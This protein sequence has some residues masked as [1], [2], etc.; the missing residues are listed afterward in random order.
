MK[1]FSQSFFTFLHISNF[2]TQAIFFCFHKYKACETIHV[3]GNNKKSLHF[4]NF[5]FFSRSSSLFS[6]F[7]I[8]FVSSVS[9]ART[10]ASTNMNEV[11]SRSH[12]IFNI[13][14]TQSE[15]GTETQSKISL[16]DLAGSERASVSNQKER[17]KEGSNINKSLT[18]LGKIISGLSE[19]SKSQHMTNANKRSS[20]TPADFIPYRFVCFLENIYQQ[21]DSPELT[22]APCDR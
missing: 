10:V 14:L 20:K 1:R 12:A 3:F 22:I 7:V 19:N 15:D 16:V 17:L 6:S 11:S 18:T 9:Q 8:I 5:V 2:G 4:Y 21:E 13:I